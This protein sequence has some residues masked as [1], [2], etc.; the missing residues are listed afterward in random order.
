LFQ[1]QQRDVEKQSSGVTAVIGLCDVLHRD[2]DA[3][4]TSVESRAIMEAKTNLELRWKNILQ[5]SFERK[6]R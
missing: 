4:P 1:D 3:C 2:S 5:L 6:Q